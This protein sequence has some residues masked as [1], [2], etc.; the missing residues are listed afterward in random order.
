MNVSQHLRVYSYFDFLNSAIKPERYLD[1][2]IQ[3]K[4]QI[5]PLTNT[6]SVFGMMDF[7]IDAEKR[8]LKPI[9]GLTISQIKI[10]TQI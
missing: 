6:N 4:S 7:A 3:E 8:G 2:L 1:F 9:L 5:A 10:K